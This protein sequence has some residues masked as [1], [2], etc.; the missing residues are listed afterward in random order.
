MSD[1]ARSAAES[2]PAIALG[3]SLDIVSTQTALLSN[4]PPGVINMAKTRRFSN[5]LIALRPSLA[6]Y[7]KNLA[8]STS[9]TRVSTGLPEYYRLIDDL[10]LVVDDFLRLITNYAP[11]KALRRAF[12]TGTDTEAFGL[13]YERLGNCLDELNIPFP[14]ESSVAR[15]Q[16]LLDESSDLQD[17]VV[18]LRRAVAEAPREANLSHRADP[19]AIP[20]GERLSTSQLELLLRRLQGRQRNEGGV[21]GDYSTASSVQ[22]TG[23]GAGTRVH[24][25]RST[26]RPF[27]VIDR[28]D[29]RIKELIGSGAWGKVY[30][31]YWHSTEVAV[32]K[33][34]SG[35]TREA[36][37]SFIHEVE[38]NSA[39]DHPGIVQVY[40]A[41]IDKDPFLMVMEYAR[42][43][44][45]YNFLQK[46][47]QGKISPLPLGP[48]I[49]VLVQIARALSA[50]HN[51]GIAHRDLKSLNVLITGDRS[52]SGGGLQVK[53]ADF[54]QAK[55]KQEVT[56][57]LNT[58]V[59]TFRWMAP[60]VLRNQ[61]P[62]RASADVYSF[63]MLAFEV[64]TCT[65]PFSELSDP[66][67]IPVVLGLGR[68]K[69][70]D[71]VPKQLQDIV[72]ECW[73]D[74]PE[75]RP[76]FSAV[77]ARLEELPE[78][79]LWQQGRNEL[80][81][82]ADDEFASA[83]LSE[84][85]Q[86]ILRE[87]QTEAAK[88]PGVAIKDS[89]YL[90]TL[91]DS[92]TVTALIVQDD[93]VYSAAG[94]M[95]HVWRMGTQPGD[96]LIQADSVPAQSTEIWCLLLVPGKGTKLGRLYSGSKDGFIKA[97]SLTNQRLLRTARKQ[98][99]AILALASHEHMLISSSDDGVVRMLDPKSLAVIGVADQGSDSYALSLCCA[100]KELLLGMNDGE[101][102]KCTIGL[103]AVACCASTKLGARCKLAATVNAHNQAISAICMMES[104]ERFVTSS[105]DGSVKLWSLAKLSLL[106]SI[107]AHPKSNVLALLVSGD[108]VYSGASDKMIKKWNMTA[109]TLTKV[110][111]GHTGSVVSLALAGDTLLS[112]STDKTIKAW[113]VGSDANAE[114]P[115]AQKVNPDL[116]AQSGEPS[117]AVLL[118]PE[119]VT[120]IR[121]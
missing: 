36:K 84:L 107:E 88:L 108:S 119:T 5:R 15:S 19:A 55:V 47:H 34:V 79:K 82:A 121:V 14:V 91:V 53:I 109:C 76:P 103:K 51:V 120:P 70:P 97:W 35:I 66:Q 12:R 94:N 29:L 92:G 10:R 9:N 6:E 52:A 117:P 114:Q 65:I 71:T 78:Y 13:L 11:E 68:P 95:I 115:P 116:P 75:K 98:P 21:E 23:S 118:S 74:D 31:A 77:T 104:A 33:L 63:A 28:L 45:L 64:L 90:S 86:I 17:L 54:G 111:Y 81:R 2:G 50:L 93:V 4:A 49:D 59:G 67:F 1:L 85:S 38:V 56:T 24:T 32:K 80:L 22:F 60:E 18:L 113:R 44:S 100:G 105:W 25:F 37:E 40:G 43:G 83:Q 16:D 99:G 57:A 72:V 39:M 20:E 73:D 30:R 112:G 89:T 41:C 27:N 26:T 106:Q 69:L 58:Q 7:Y 8:D 42:H 102:R 110:M 62:Y 48:S 46:A 101:L 87:T 61:P 3:K 96:Q